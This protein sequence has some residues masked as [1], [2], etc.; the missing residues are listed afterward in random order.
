MKKSLIFVASVSFA[1]ALSA[2]CCAQE[3]DRS[4]MS[5]EEW[6]AHVE[7]S[8]QRIEL[9]RRQHKN[10]VPQEPSQDEIAEAASKRVLQDDSLKP[11]DIISTTHGLF[12]FLGATGRQPTPDDF[13]RLR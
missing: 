2:N 4:Q 8:R 7:A 13:V 10:F 5:R 6:Q 1:A 3:R 12:R 9:M 11:G